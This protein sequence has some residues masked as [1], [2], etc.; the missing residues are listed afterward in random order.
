MGDPFKSA[1]FLGQIATEVCLAQG[2]WSVKPGAERAQPKR[3]NYRMS[4]E[5]V[6]K[7][8]RLIEEARYFEVPLAVQ[9]SRQINNDLEDQ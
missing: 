4:I 2:R 7:P 8:V 3:I 5:K 6:Q 9:T 1:C